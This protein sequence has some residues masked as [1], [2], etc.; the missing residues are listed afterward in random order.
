MINWD[1]A[2]PFRFRL[3]NKEGRLGPEV[4]FELPT[5][6]SFWADDLDHDGKSELVS[7]SQFSGRAQ[8]SH[9]IRKESPA[10]SGQL[11]HG[12]KLRGMC[13]LI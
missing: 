12:A 10:L 9:F 6:R 13:S 1:S 11:K 2:N 5:I 4:H 7:I 3:Q 8:L